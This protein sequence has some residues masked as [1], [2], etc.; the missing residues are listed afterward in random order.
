MKKTHFLLAFVISVGVLCSCTKTPKPTISSTGIYD[1]QSIAYIQD[2]NTNKTLYG[3]IDTNDKTVYIP[4][5]YEQIKYFTFGNIVSTREIYVGEKDGTYTLFDYKGK[6]I[7]DNVTDYEVITKDPI[8][9]HCPVYLNITKGGRKYVI[10]KDNWPK[11][12]GPYEDIYITSGKVGFFKHGN[13]WGAFKHSEHRILSVREKETDGNEFLPAEFDYLFSCGPELTSN[14]FSHYVGFKD[15]QWYLFDD[16]GEIV[17][18][19]FKGLNPERVR[20]LPINSRENFADRF[21]ESRTGNSYVGFYPF[22]VSTKYIFSNE[23]DRRLWM[24][25]EVRLGDPKDY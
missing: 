19:N 5:E 10:F 12:F 2:K 4:F 21:D 23:H 11:I 3:V 24:A 22:T 13:K 18:E 25:M 6:P 1:W 14:E 9:A 7:C 17:T 20:N 8:G 16:S 15:G